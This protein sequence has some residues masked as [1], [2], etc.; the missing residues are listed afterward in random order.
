[1]NSQKN[2]KVLLTVTLPNPC[3]RLAVW[4]RDEGSPIKLF[5]KYGNTSPV[6]TILD[7]EVS[8]WCKFSNKA[9]LCSEQGI[10]DTLVWSKAQLIQFNVIQCKTAQ[11]IT[12]QNN[13]FEN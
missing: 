11:Y 8:I 1:M 6:V 2:K 4:G 10:I 13:I 3:K 7:Y 12:M 5:Q 9:R